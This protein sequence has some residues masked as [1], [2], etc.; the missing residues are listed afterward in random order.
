MDFTLIGIFL[1]GAGTIQSIFL[2]I[3]FFFS[4]KLERQERIL[5]GLLFLLISLRLIKSIGWY[6]FKIENNIFLNIGFAAHAFI[7]PVLLCY[8]S[9]RLQS[10]K[11]NRWVISLLFVPPL[12]LFLTIPFL[13][14]NNFWYQGGYTALLY[15]TVGY[16][17]IGGFFLKRIYQ[18]N[19]KSLRMIIILFVA[20]GLFCLL[21]FTNYVL[22]IHEYITGPILYA[23]VIYATS[24]FLFR[25]KELLT[26]KVES[27][28]QNINITKN[29]AEIYSKAIEKV[30]MDERPYLDGD[31]NLGMLAEYTKTPKHLLSLVFSTI[32]QQSFSSF[33][34]AY[35]IKEAEKLLKDEKYQ[36]KKIEIVAYD[37]G[38]NS[39]S[40][41]N[42]AFRKFNKCS[43]SEYRKQYLEN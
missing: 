41:F 36:N 42:T 30:M 24:Y 11:L 14:L 26:V 7:V 40:T 6:F 3:F 23:L 25:N 10:N 32:F 33:T 12:A 37:S 2:S 28:Y 9:K 18:E 5:L 15:L 1:C 39:V 16:L 22:G 38:F 19:G 21:Y 17:I 20:I 43:P 27:K 13:T 34:N 35:R 4:K 29:Q 31:F 8:L